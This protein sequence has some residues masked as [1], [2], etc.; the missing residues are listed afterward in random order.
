M[1]QEIP[2][3]L[4]TEIDDLSGYVERNGS[5]VGVSTPIK[6]VAAAI[7]RSGPVGEIPADPAGRDHLMGMP[8][9]S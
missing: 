5:Q 8:A 4:R 7:V 3:S 2:K 9:R 6:T 1:L